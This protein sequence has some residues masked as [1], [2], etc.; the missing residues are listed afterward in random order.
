MKKTIMKKYGYICQEMV[1]DIK[2]Y[3][4]DFAFAFNSNFDDNVFQFNCDFFKCINPFDNVQIKDIR[5]FA[6]KYIIDNKYKKFCEE[7]E[8]FTDSGNYSTT[9]ESVYKYITNNIDFEEKHTALED[10]IIETEILINCFNKGGKPTEELQAKK[11]IPREIRKDLTI[12]I[13]NKKVAV[14]NC[15]KYTVYKK[16]NTIKIEK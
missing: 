13:N 12:V 5:A 7:N 4:I 15:K 1:R 10:S 3:N 16:R 6:H 8:L 9:A 2:K 14:I 11:S